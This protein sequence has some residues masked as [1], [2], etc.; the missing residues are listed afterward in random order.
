MYRNFAVDDEATNEFGATV[1]V[2]SS[3]RNEF[4]KL[5]VVALCATN[6]SH[7][8]TSRVVKTPSNLHQRLFDEDKIIAHVRQRRFCTFFV[9]T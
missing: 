9:D 4:D 6:T 3:Q 8:G 1:S 5:R 2:L 7:A